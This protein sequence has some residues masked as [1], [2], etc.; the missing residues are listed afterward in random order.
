MRE[1]LHAHFLAATESNSKT[2]EQSQV[3]A[4]LA[5]IKQLITINLEK[6]SILQGCTRQGTALLQQKGQDSLFLLWYR[7]YSRFRHGLDR[8]K[9][10]SRYAIKGM[11]EVCRRDRKRK[12]KVKKL[13]IEEI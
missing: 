4:N 12:M 10:E 5:K 2:R 7:N 1:H 13:F 3:S 9:K 11:Q 8:N 6:F